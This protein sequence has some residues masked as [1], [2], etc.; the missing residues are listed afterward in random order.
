MSGK[1]E[2]FVKFWGGA[3]PYIENE[4]GIKENN[5]WFDT[6]KEREEFID[7]LRP[8]SRYGLAMDTQEGSLTHKRTIAKVKVE[9]ENKEHEIT[10]DFGYEYPEGGV[11]FMFEDGDYACDC[12]LSLFLNRQDSTFKRMDCGNKIKIKDI[13]VEYED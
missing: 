11:L 4:L 5:H 8:F 6:K 10:Q 1:T 12:N 7:K 2:Y 3:D 9:Y 13:K